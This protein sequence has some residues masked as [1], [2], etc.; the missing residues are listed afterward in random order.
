MIIYYECVFLLCACLVIK[1][2]R[3]LPQIPGNKYRLL[4]LCKCNNNQLTIAYHLISCISN[5][6]V[7]GVVPVLPLSHPA[8]RYRTRGCWNVS[9]KSGASR[10]LRAESASK[11]ARNLD[12][13]AHSNTLILSLSKRYLRAGWYLSLIS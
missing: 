13:C 12:D 3:T 1:A 8:L 9:F 11:N 4:R 7:G 2:I 5:T 6:C 10:L